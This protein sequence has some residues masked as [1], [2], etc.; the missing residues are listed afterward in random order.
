M[1]AQNE[2]VETPLSAAVPTA[3]PQQGED[4]RPPLNHT[5]EQARDTV[6]SPFFT[7]VQGEATRPWVTEA[8]QQGHSARH[9][10]NSTP[11]LVEVTRPAV[12]TGPIKREATGPQPNRMP[13][14]TI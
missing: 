8:P 7:S 14:Q 12:S 2:E 5:L 4:V 6:P 1:V 9:P 10:P 3:V 13:E 11:E